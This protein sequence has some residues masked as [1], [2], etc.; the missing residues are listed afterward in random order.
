[1]TANLS[2][3]VT[4]ALSITTTSLVNGAQGAAYSAS[5]SA[6]GGVPS[7]TFSLATGSSLPANLTISAA[8][9]ITGTPTAPG[10][11][12]FTVQATDASNPAQTA[13]A[14]LS[15]TVTSGLTITT[16]SLPNGAEASP[17]TTSVST[18]GGVLPYTFSLSTGS[19]LP[20][21][22]TISAAG[23][24]SGTPTAPGT[25]GFTVQVRDSSP[26]PQ[27]ASAGLSIT[28]GGTLQIAATTLPQ[29][30]VGDS[31]TA[32]LTGLG[33][34]APYTFS[35]AGGSALPAGLTIS[36][37]GIISGKPTAAGTSTFTVQLRDSTGTPVT[38]TAQLSITVNGPLAFTTTSLPSISLTGGLQVGYQQVIYA[39][40]GV[41]P[42]TF[43]VLSGTLP[44]GVTLGGGFGVPFGTEG[45]SI[46]GFGPP[47]GSGTYTFTVQV[48]DSLG[49][50]ATQ[51]LS[52]TV[53][54]ATAVPLQ[55]TTTSLPNGVVG[56]AYT[57]SIAATGGTA[58]YTFS[59][60]GALPRGLTMS[61]TGIIAGTPLAA[62]TSN[63]TVRVRDSSA[64]PQTTTANLSI[65]VTNPP[66]PQI[67]T[68]DLPNGVVGTAYNASITATGGNAPYTF[69]LT[70]AL[71]RGLTMSSAGIIAGSP[72]AAG[73]S[74]FTVHVRDSSATPQTATANLSIFVSNTPVTPLQIT[75]TS[76]PNGIQGTPYTATVSATG[77]DQPYTF[78]A[79]GLPAGLTMNVGGEI[80]GTP[81]TGGTFSVQVRVHDAENPAQTTTAL[82]TLTVTAP[83]LQITTTTLPNGIVGTAYTARV[84]ATGGLAP[85]TF[86]ATGLPAGLTMSSGGVITGTPLTASP[87]FEVQ[88]LVHDAENPAQTTTAYLFLAVTA[89]LQITTTS[90]PNGIMNTAYT[91]TVIATGGVAPYTFSATGLPVG[92]TMSSSGVISGTPLTGSPSFHVRVQVQDAENPAQTTTA[93][94]TLA[95]APLLQIATTS[96][97]NGVVGTAYR[98]TVTATG[99]F[100]PYTFSATGMPAGLTMSS[101]GVITG[102]PTTATIIGGIV[103]ISFVTVEVHDAE[104]PAQ[105]VSTYLNLNVAAPLQITTTSLPAGS[106]GAL[107][108][109]EIDY[110]GGIPPYTFSIIGGSL[111]PGLSIDPS[112]GF[113]YIGGFLPTTAGNWRFTVRVQ[114]SSS[115]AMT[116]TETLTIAVTS[117]GGGTPTP[118]K[119]AIT[120]TSLPLAGTG[121]YYANPIGVTGGYEPYAISVAGGSLPPG[122]TLVSGAIQG[123]PTTTGT[124]AFTLVVTDG[125]SPQQRATQRLTIRVIP[126]VR[127]VTTSLP[128][129]T[130]NTNYAANIIVTGGTAPYTYSY[131]AVITITGPTTI[132][133][134]DVNI[135]PAGMG[136]TS[137]GSNG[138]LGIGGTPTGPAGVTSFYVTVKDANG[139]LYT[140]LFNL[141]VQQ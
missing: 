31:Y 99:G 40:G 66:P 114:D 132:G 63:F 25:T 68:I 81:A 61:S 95:V 47:S 89:P 102:T 37:G 36:A 34:N 70:G 123:T 98:V 60:T 46:G 42:F 6:T 8:G 139:L 9:L 2:I 103:G 57:A 67:T 54:T 27:T 69:S 105:T 97:P 124:Y 83:P 115:P 118:R 3:T 5:V 111:P 71:P 134:G 7:Y 16:A 26:T 128:A 78:S 19:V 73:V 59:F 24:I 108:G 29:G 120:T 140:Q 65:V 10:T 38:V 126:G 100:A 13:T 12:I 85:Y 93:S 131:I 53:I 90:L 96:L 94:L 39:Q 14:V 109:S 45:I 82:L 49:D 55:F 122:L 136:T 121:D 133:G 88:V 32:T 1:M 77:G 17:Y 141:T 138:V 104:N 72:L 52:I 92:L 101:R 56:I 58:P 43:T 62:G 51:Q 119:L 30:V 18:A 129:A 28:I 137:D 135:L 50:T 112:V 130:I 116:V 11:T 41:G 84:A 35:L 80:T 22:L 107:Y 106:T 76:L 44:P 79:T 48:T 87:F 33:G 15:I 21:G 91:A 74:N 4:P 125:S 110:S 117:P 64:T 75:T 20:P 113:A 86:T 127:F 23:V